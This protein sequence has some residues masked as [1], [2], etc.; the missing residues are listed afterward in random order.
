MLLGYQPS[1]NWNIYAGGIYQQFEGELKA[2]EQT[3]Q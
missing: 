2:L 3:I 1:V